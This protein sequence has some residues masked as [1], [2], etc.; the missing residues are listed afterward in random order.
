MIRPEGPAGMY[1]P[2]N[3]CKRASISRES[4]I[5]DSRSR[6]LLQTEAASSKISLIIWAGSFSGLFIFPLISCPSKYFPSKISL[7]IRAGSFSGEFIYTLIKSL[8]RQSTSSSLCPFD[9]PFSEIRLWSE[10]SS[11]RSSPRNPAINLR[12]EILF[13]ILSWSSYL[14]IEFMNSTF[15]SPLGICPKMCIPLWIWLFLILPRTSCAFLIISSK[16][17]S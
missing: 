12:I 1:P 17:V 15:F 13:P 4:S 16:G 3:P 14:K 6:I 2:S 8:E 10:I 11:S 5:L 7:I 9:F